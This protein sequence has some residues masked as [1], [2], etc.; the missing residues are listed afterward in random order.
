M[1]FA[2]IQA[3]LL[4][5]ETKRLEYEKNHLHSTTLAQANEISLGQKHARELSDARLQAENSLRL[6]AESAVLLFSNAV[7][8]LNNPLNHVL[9][10]TLYV[11]HITSE[12]RT[13]SMTSLQRIPS[14]PRPRRFDY[15]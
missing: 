13:S 11:N 2:L 3:L 5:R 6:E 12:V 14:M 1:I 4:A 9:G 8:H 7:H 15:A 10:A